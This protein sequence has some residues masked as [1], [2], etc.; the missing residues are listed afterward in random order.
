MVVLSMLCGLSSAPAAERVDVHHPPDAATWTL[1]GGP[2]MEA[3]G[4][5]TLTQ[6]QGP[7]PGLW[8]V[9]PV[10]DFALRVRAPL[11]TITQP[12][13]QA[14]LRLTA[15]AAD[16]DRA[17]GEGTAL[18]LTHRIHDSLDF[19]WVTATDSDGGARTTSRSPRFG[20]AIF[21]IS[22]VNA[23][24]STRFR[25][26]APG[27]PWGAPDYA[28]EGVPS[29]TFLGQP[30]DIGVYVE[31]EYNA[32]WTVPI[33]SV[34]VWQDADADGLLDDEEALMGSDPTQGDSD[35]DGT[36]DGADV[37]PLDPRQAIEVS[38]LQAR[39]AAG[40][41][42]IRGPVGWYVHLDGS[43][44]VSLDGPLELPGLR[45]HMA[46]VK[47][48]GDVAT[49]LAPLDD[50]ALV[51]VPSDDRALFW[52]DA[53]RAPV[54]IPDLPAVRV[55]GGADV[56]RTR[57]D[58][59]RYVVDPEGAP[60]NFELLTVRSSVPAFIPYDIV[61]STLTL[62]GP[63]E[64][65]TAWLDLR[66][67]DD[68]GGA[69]EFSVAL[70]LQ[71]DVGPPALVDGDFATPG[72]VRAPWTFNLWEGD[73]D[74][75][76]EPSVG[77]SGADDTAARILGQGPGKAAFY[78]RI[79]LTP[80]R[81]RLT[82]KVAS[83]ELQRG[84]FN[85]ASSFYLSGHAPTPLNIP[86]V[87]GDSGWR[88]FEVVFEVEAGAPTEVIAYFF[89]WGAGALFVDDVTL[90]AEPPCAQSAL[91]ATVGE[92]ELPLDAA[93]PA[94]PEDDL[95]CPYCPEVE[96]DA[97]SLCARCAD[98][99]APAAP[100]PTRVLDAFEPGVPGVFVRPEFGAERLRPLAGEASAQLDSDRFMSATPASGLPTDWRGWDWL[101]VDVR[102]DSDAPVPF[103]VE[104]R[105]AATRDYWTRVNWYTAAAPGVS[106]VQVPLQVFVGEKSVIRERRRLQLDAITRLVFAHS[107]GAPLVFDDVRLET[108]APLPS[109]DP[110]ILKLDF[111]PATGSVFPAFTG[112]DA[113]VDFRSRR[114]YGF[115][116][117]TRVGRVEDRRHPDPLRRDWVSVLSGGFGLT[118]PTGRYAVWMVLE[119]PGYWEYFPS[120]ER[121]VVRA[122][123]AT[124]LDEQPNLDA[125]LERYYAH[126]DDD[127]PIDVDVPA[128][129]LSPR[130]VPLRFEVE[131]MDGRLDVEFEGSTYACALSALV[132]APSDARG[133]TP[134]PDLEGFLDGLDAR[135]ASHFEGESLRLRR[136]E[137][138]WPEEHV[139]SPFVL[140]GPPPGTFIDRDARPP[141]GPPLEAL[142]ATAARGEA[143]PLSVAL[144]VAGDARGVDI[145][146]VELTLPGA[147]VNSWR[148][149]HLLE[150]VT[151]DGGV[152]R[153]AP[154]LLAPLDDA[155]MRE[156]VAAGETR[157]WVFDVRPNAGDEPSALEGSFDLTYDGGR[158]MSVPVRVHV[159]RR[160]LVSLASTGLQVGWLG[161]APGMS[162]AVYP[163][164]EARRRALTLDALDGL[165]RAGFSAVT[166]GLGAGP[167]LTGF[168]A[169]G[170]ALLDLTDAAFTLDALAA[171]A[172]AWPGAVSTY[173]GLAWGGLPL[174]GTTPVV[175]G[176]PFDEA[177]HSALSAFEGAR[178]A[179][180]WPRVRISV[181][182]E[183]AGEAAAASTALAQAI[184]ATGLGVESDVFTSLEG[185]DDPR[186]ALV[187]AVDLALLTH[188]T[189][190]ALDLLHARGERWGLYN[191]AGRYRRGL[192]LYA[193]RERGLE[194]YYQ[195]AFGSAGADP[196]Y[197][198]DAREDDL[199]AVFTHPRYGLLPTTFARGFER[200]VSDLRVALTLERAAA[201]S[202]VG[203]A[204]SRAEAWLAQRVL[205]APV[206]HAT[207]DPYDDTQLEA[208]RAEA[209]VL[210][211]A[212]DSAEIL[213]DADAPLDAARPADAETPLDA[214]APPDAG[215][216][217]DAEP[218]FDAAPAPDTASALDATS[219]IDASP[220]TD[221]APPADFGPSPDEGRAVVDA[222]PRPPT[223]PRQGAGSCGA[224]RASAHPG[225]SALMLLSLAGL[226]RARAH[227]RGRQRPRP[228]PDPRSRRSTPPDDRAAHARPRAP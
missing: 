124:V 14:S 173:G 177:L 140:S 131:V 186:M 103:T 193:L 6:A 207:R 135:M 102:N 150:R 32:A 123:G 149:R 86:L 169:D 220:P 106:T 7:R 68:A 170:A 51:S 76:V 3:N 2:L 175:H 191:Q 223:A 9:A 197:A 4:V 64:C 194:A 122:E 94:R 16:F 30:E 91:G 79:Q 152:Y 43:H 50:A 126:A 133:L 49:S 83:A 11:Q 205:E 93:L 138:P 117:G 71:G 62:S 130:Y 143:T 190:D 195:F 163:E 77:P 145:D 116:P 153:V 34:Q 111:G 65:G 217:S 199:C 61:G 166:G 160:P 179:H 151:F 48:D 58:L 41:R 36:P 134:P 109:D 198:L 80:G 176:R 10:G 104:I 225:P 112:V 110:R 180:A 73:F 17:R 66:A 53:N 54:A 97:P 52:F 208:L 215:V 202:P 15:A 55:P 95:L 128:T 227:R 105:D 188:H 144:H 212:L 18:H 164:V 57:I 141:T 60:L 82:A 25:R 39:G 20:E 146:R 192:Y 87:S 90:S 63:A 226:L 214:E 98:R 213:L 201:E 81:W 56:E 35:G 147:E 13:Y 121:R 67:S 27:E 155:A 125:W 161:H 74:G 185:A 178:Q 129:Y 114:A 167:V 156:R 88:P 72:P 5:M 100:P 209:F 211:D 204:R 174:Y 158:R 59:S 29:P 33:R 89:A 118:L 216:V 28:N 42:W 228:Q 75:R 85:L 78:Q 37:A 136:P 31:P 157:Q 107:G 38:A 171:R 219:L 96:S 119:D 196:Y 218:A 92:V 222:S 154:R 182:D 45:A 12:G 183:P 200:A 137:L 184:R 44:D 69:I 47:L 113:S 162:P 23:T 22:R 159:P 221:G 115:L 139:G 26:L 142:V 24:W 120:F 210:L 21:E 19:S 8:R 46:V 70:S 168:D 181:G 1:R 108:E 101:R 84:T 99:P 189:T 127:L 165:A 172:A 148:V 132:V 224:V 206:G 187:E 203:P 40:V